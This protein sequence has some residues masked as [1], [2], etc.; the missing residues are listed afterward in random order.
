MR[1]GLPL[2]GL[3]REAWLNLRSGVTRATTLATAF[4]LTAGGLAFA[5]MSLTQTAVHEAV[6]FQASGASTLVL[7]AGGMVDGERCALLAQV[8][9]VQAAGALRRLPDAVISTLPE[10][11]ASAFAATTGLA[12]VLGVS[13]P[14]PMGAWVSGPLAAD[15]GTREGAILP[16]GA[17][18]ATVAGVFPYPDDGRDR[19]LAYAM[20]SEVPVTGAF[21]ECWITVWPQNPQVQ[22]LL[23]AVADTPTGDD[24]TQATIGALNTTRGIAFDRSGGALLREWILSAEVVLGLAM[25]ALTVRIRRLELIGALHAGVGKPALAT[26]IV[27]ET[28]AWLSAAVALTG[29]AFWVVA[30][31]EEVPTA[32][33]LF[34]GALRLM[35]CAT[36]ATMVGALVS[37]LALRRRMLYSYFL[38]R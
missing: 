18:D 17:D 23:S 4:I 10:A 11:P 5:G 26:Q 33:S 25:G 27:I 38:S 8:P 3:I 6:A 36:V 20:V 2:A 24:R 29:A 28:T 31:S 13:T 22:A 16:L 19:A 32:L 37:V 1:R 7:K 9:G 12:A 30:A 14:Q 35:G 15:L 21:D 34:L